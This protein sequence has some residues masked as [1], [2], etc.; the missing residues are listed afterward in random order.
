MLYALDD[1]DQS[2]RAYEIV[3]ERMPTDRTALRGAAMAHRKKNNYSA[4]AARL[5]DI[6]RK[7]PK[8]AEVWMNLGDVA[9]YQG[10][11]MVA[12][13]SYTKAIE[14]DPQAGDVIEQARD[15]LVLMARKSRGQQR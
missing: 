2:L 9:I 11:D 3:L 7:N 10:D 4:A 12:R 15:R 8:D 6:L 5:R 13:Q 14:V 1:F